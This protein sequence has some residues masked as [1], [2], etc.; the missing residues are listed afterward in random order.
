[1][2][3]YLADSITMQLK[4]PAHLYFANRLFLLNLA[5]IYTTGFD[6]PDTSRVIPELKLMLPAVRKIYESYNATFPQTPVTKTFLAQYDQMTRFAADQPDMFSRFDRYEFIRN[7]V[8]P[9]FSLNQEMIRNY[10][11]YSRSYNDFAL[12]DQ[13]VSIFDKSLYKAQTT[14]GIFSFVEDPAV[15]RGYTC[16]REIVIL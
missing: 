2:D 1:M 13:A 8:N 9:L 14:K 4:K 11:M 7:Y 5:A 12:N 16:N 6:C 15:L 3:T 10:K